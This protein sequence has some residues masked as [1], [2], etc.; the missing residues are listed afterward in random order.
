ME[1]ADVRHE[2]LELPAFSFGLGY[3]V[4]DCLHSAQRVS[5]QR[6]QLHQTGI[7]QQPLRAA[8]IAEGMYRLCSSHGIIQQESHTRLK[9]AI[10]MP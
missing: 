7:S 6:D 1:G 10:S 2:R 3:L 4:K 5:D 8:G 9:R